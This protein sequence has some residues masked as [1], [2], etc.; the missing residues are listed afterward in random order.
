MKKLICC[1]LAFAF[2]FSFFGCNERPKEKKDEL[3]APVYDYGAESID[4]NWET[5]AENTNPNFKYFG[6]YHSDALLSDKD[7]SLPYGYIDAIAE[8]G[9]ANMFVLNQSAYRTLEQQAE[10]IEHAHTK[11]MQTIWQITSFMFSGTYLKNRYKEA[12]DTAVEGLGES[13]DYVYAFY[14][15]EPSWSGISKSDF[16]A[17]TKYLSET[18][19]DKHIMTCLAIPELNGE[20]QADA[21]YFYYCT[22]MAFDYYGAFDNAERLE[23]LNK[24]KTFATNNQW[25][26]GVAT[27]FTNTPDAGVDIIVNSIK[28]EYATGLAEP[29]YRG[30]LSFSFATGINHDWGYGMRDFLMSDG[31]YYE[32]YGETLLTLYKQIGNAIIANA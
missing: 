31:I 18:Y 19:P 25:L 7:N 20:T 27:G 26:W 28:G 16:L 8:I 13:F 23:L 2:T 9:N 10:Y 32:Q 14:I 5:L 4:Y 6:Y 15:D 1:L 22:D 11:G 30:I 21:E 12:I 3:R 29:R 24:L 17:A